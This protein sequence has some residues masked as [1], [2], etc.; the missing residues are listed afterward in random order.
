[1][2]AG[3][4]AFFSLTSNHTLTLD[5]SN[6]QFSG[7]KGA[8][9]S[10]RDTTGG[11]IFSA[12]NLKLTGNAIF[13]GTETGEGNTAYYGGALGVYGRGTNNIEF[14]GDFQFL[15]NSAHY[16]G[17]AIYTGGAGADTV[18]F[19]GGTYTFTGNLTSTSG[20]G[21]AIYADT[22]MFSGA[23]SKATFTGNKRGVAFDSDG[24]PVADT[25]TNNDI[26]SDGGNVTIQDGGTYF[27]GGGIA[28]SYDYSEGSLTIGVDGQDGAPDVTFGNGSVSNVGSWEI[29][30]GAGVTLESGSQFTVDEGL[31]L[32]GEN[33]TLVLG[34][35][36]K[37]LSMGSLNVSEKA[38]LVLDVGNGTFTP[39]EVNGAALFGDTST[40]MLDF[41]DTF[42]L[43]GDLELLLFTVDGNYLN[44]ATLEWNQPAGGD[45]S[46]ELIVQAMQE[47]NYKQV[48]AHISGNSNPNPVPE[49]TTWAMLLLGLAT[50]AIYARRKK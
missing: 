33:S 10:G 41:G 27:F 43:S 22:T 2:T 24:K 16:A 6:M 50:L 9:D 25:G 14:D 26:Y 40:L 31:S 39:F 21:G 18:T 37:S 7:G 47:S 46:V 42:S 8:T 5:L 4:G 48:Y 1:M 23:G 30:H 45:I 32:A 20:S 13:G 28:V 36:M 44:E 17:G 12:G 38:S 35:N 34:N 15:N 19:S 49:P 29:G 3:S 11:A